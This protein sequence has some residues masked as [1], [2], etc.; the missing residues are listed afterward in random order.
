MCVSASLVKVGGVGG[1]GGDEEGAEGEGR[2]EEE[3][4]RG[5]KR[6]ETAAGTS[7]HT[8]ATR[9]FVCVLLRVSMCLCE[10]I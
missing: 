7:L 3:A 8:S 9:L 1:G 5:R 4:E 2:E 10:H 6:V